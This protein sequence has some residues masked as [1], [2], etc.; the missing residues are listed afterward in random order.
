MKKTKKK[1]QKNE[2]RERERGRF[3]GGVNLVILHEGQFHPLSEGG[4]KQLSFAS[5]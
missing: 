4:E 3:G 5:I 1:L 2:E